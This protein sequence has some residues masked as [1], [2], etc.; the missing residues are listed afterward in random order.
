MADG[1]DA[2][3]RGP[4]LKR[5]R[6]EKFQSFDTSTILADNLLFISHQARN[7][8]LLESLFSPFLFAA[9]IKILAAKKNRGDFGHFNGLSNVHSRKNIRTSFVVNRITIFHSE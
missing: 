1:S 8:L 4:L 2:T 9:K 5:D 6:W 3:C 7:L